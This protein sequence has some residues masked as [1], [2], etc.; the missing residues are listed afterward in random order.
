MGMILKVER[1]GVLRHVGS[2]ERTRNPSAGAKKTID[3]DRDQVLSRTESA[4]C[5][6]SRPLRLIGALR[7]PATP[8]DDSAGKALG[9]HAAASHYLPHC[10]DDSAAGASGRFA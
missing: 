1:R 7:A 3:F 6:A 4:E 2:G 8:R 10:A 9:C 5:K